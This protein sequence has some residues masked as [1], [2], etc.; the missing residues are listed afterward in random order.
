MK[1][2]AEAIQRPGA[3][4]FQGSCHLPLDR[5]IAHIEDRLAAGDFRPHEVYGALGD[6]V[7]NRSSRDSKSV[8]PR[9][10]E[11]LAFYIY[12]AVRKYFEQNFAAEATDSLVLAQH[13]FFA[14]PPGV[15]LK[16]HADDHA[17][18]PDGSVLARD[19]HRGITAIL[20]LNSAFSGGEIAFPK[21]GLSISPSAG[22]LVIFP[23]N[24]N[25]PHEVKPILSGWRYSYQR[26][27]GVLRVEGRSIGFA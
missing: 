19:E 6:S 22:K 3:A 20:Y 16:L 5:C 12:E 11:E 14:Y 13:D 7:V 27:Y 26:I 8:T 18:G 2:H 10:D 21:Q 25:F 15:G 1:T 23:A 9:H 24:R 4:I 17:L